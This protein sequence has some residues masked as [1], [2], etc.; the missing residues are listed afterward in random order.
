MDWQFILIIIFGAVLLITDWINVFPMLRN[1]RK[2]I[3]FSI[4]LMVLFVLHDAI[5]ILPK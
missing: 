3:T 4:I 1:N 2:Y 5:N